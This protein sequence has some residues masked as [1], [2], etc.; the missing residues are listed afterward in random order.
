MW[1]PV[2]S[3]RR[4]RYATSDVGGTHCEM[5]KR[6]TPANLI[7]SHP[8][9]TNAVRYGVHSPTFI[10]EL[11][12]DL[13][14]ELFGQCKLSP[15]QRVAAHEVAT[16][17][18]LLQRIDLDLEER[19]IVDKK[20]DARY[21]LALRVRVSRELERWAQHLTEV[22]PPANDKYGFNKAMDDELARIGA[23]FNSDRP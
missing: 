14:T 15:V 6:G 13:E 2:G 19:G 21:L 23:R 10:R 5:N 4:C 20:G 9:N 17:L 3:G 12:T 16:N 1:C 18:A 7:P 11:A 8:G 22:A